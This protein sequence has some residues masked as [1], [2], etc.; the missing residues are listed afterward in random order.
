M[1]RKAHEIVDLIAPT[2]QLSAPASE[3]DIISVHMRGDAV[4][5]VQTQAK[6]GL[7]ILISS[8]HG[9]FSDGPIILCQVP[10]D[11][12]ERHKIRF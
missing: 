6:T 10:E 3:R 4:S 8:L 1:V 7:K 2:R 5:F 12:E 11:R 9:L